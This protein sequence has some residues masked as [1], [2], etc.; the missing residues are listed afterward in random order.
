MWWPKRFTA[1]LF[2]GPN[3][4]VA[5]D[6]THLCCQVDKFGPILVVQCYSLSN[7]LFLPDC[8]GKSFWSSWGESFQP[9]FK[10]SHFDP[11]CS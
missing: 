5:D 7:G 3:S 4:Q 6:S 11:I 2:N 9:D 1:K 10:V 8:K